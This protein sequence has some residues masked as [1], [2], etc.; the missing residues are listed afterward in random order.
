MTKRLGSVPRRSKWRGSLIGVVASLRLR[1]SERT[2]AALRCGIALASLFAVPALL[3][4]AWID[5]V[6]VTGSA[7]AEEVSAGALGGAQE[8]ECVWH[9]TV[10]DVRNSS[11]VAG[12]R[13]AWQFWRQPSSTEGIS[14][15]LWKGEFVSDKEG[16]YEVRV[17]T[18][19]V[20]EAVRS[21]GIAYDHPQYLPARES[22]WPL[23]MPAD[24]PEGLDHRNIKLT[25]GVQ[26]TGRVVLPDGTPAPNVPLMFATNRDGF[27]DFNGGFLHGFWTR[28][29]ERGRYQFHTRNTWPQ[30]VHWFPDQYES[31]SRALTETF[32]EQKTIQLKPGLALA[33]KVIDQQGQPLA[34]VVIRAVTGTR[35]PNLYATSDDK[36]IFRFTP[37]PPGQYVLAAVR[38]YVDNATGESQTTELP[39]PLPPIVCQLDAST[40]STQ[41][42]AVMRAAP[43][44]RIP[45]EVVDGAGKPL[46]DMLL[47]IGDDG[48]FPNAVRA[49]PVPAAGAVPVPL[50]AGPVYSR[51][52]RASVD[53]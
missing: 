45:V 52:A 31:N 24:P 13:V 34:G 2:A 20:D 26:V 47:S 18:A 14:Q 35:V 25:P 46:S 16:R 12:V 5:G 4:V 37:L 1:I 53:G 28:T 9:C 50:P 11:A 29:D 33:G 40:A 10:V 27:G 21:V 44:T 41:P 39:M 3:S 22:G 6:T 8:N 36:G 51:P 30:R 42:K 38:S 32:G 7:R 17:P 19:I 48:D 43:L 15:P 49:K 23:R